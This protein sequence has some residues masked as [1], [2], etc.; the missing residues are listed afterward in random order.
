MTQSFN[1]HHLWRSILTPS[2]SR[3]IFYTPRNYKNYIW[4]QGVLAPA[5]IQHQFPEKSNKQNHA[6]NC[7][8]AVFRWRPRITVQKSGGFLESEPALPFA[9]WWLATL[10]LQLLLHIAALDHFPTVFRLIF[11]ILFL[12][13]HVNSSAIMFCCFSGLLIK[14][15]TSELKIIKME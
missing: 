3:T 10:R 12:S 5:S 6:H 13:G 2:K 15:I 1:D 4:M 11:D 8:E 7:I 9:H 14:I